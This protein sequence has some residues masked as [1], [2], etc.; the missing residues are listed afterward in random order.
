MAA[1]NSV[2]DETNKNIRIMIIRLLKT[3]GLDEYNAELHQA[4]HTLLLANLA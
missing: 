2:D 4:L 3:Y 1:Y